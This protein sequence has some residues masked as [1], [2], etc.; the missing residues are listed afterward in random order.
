MTHCREKKNK[1]TMERGHLN[2]TKRTLERI[3]TIWAC[4]RE[5]GED[6]AS[7]ACSGLNVVRK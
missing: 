5:L 1:D 2:V 4:I 6:L 3:Y 7:K